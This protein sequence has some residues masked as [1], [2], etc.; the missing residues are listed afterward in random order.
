MNPLIKTK[1]H[2]L[3]FL[4]FSI[5]VFISC[6]IVVSIFHNDD[7]KHEIHPLNHSP[8]C[9]WIKEGKL[10]N[11]N[12]ATDISLAGMPFIAFFTTFCI[13]S[14][15]FLLTEKNKEKNL[16]INHFFLGSSLF[17]RAPPAKQ[18]F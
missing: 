16:P 1:K 10:C 12:T 17:S 7:E 3:S 2:F 13:F 11:R 5:A 6:S 9:Q 14:A 4:L 8:V 18:S 15:C